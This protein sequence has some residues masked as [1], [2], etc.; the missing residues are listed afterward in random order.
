MRKPFGKLTVIG[1]AE[2][3]PRGKQRMKVRCLCG[4]EKIVYL[5]DLTSGN[6]S[7]CGCLRRELGRMAKTTH[8]LC[9]SDAYRSWGAMKTRCCNPRSAGFR[10]YGGRGITICTRWQS[11]ENFYVDMGDR[12]VGKTLDRI[13]TNGPYS[14]MNC[15]WATAEEQRNNKRSLHILTVDGESKTI[16]QWSKYL[17][18]GRATLSNRILR[19]WSPERAISTPIRR[20][21]I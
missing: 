20:L 21:K 2:T 17:G 5:S 4:T 14:P 7:S 18:M 16:T 11:F 19:G 15:R 6:T 13:D 12:P 3:G 8:G 10:F 9:K 1:T